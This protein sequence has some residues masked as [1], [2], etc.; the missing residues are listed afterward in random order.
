M[1]AQDSQLVIENFRSEML[2]L[3]LSH[4]NEVSLLNFQHES[5]QSQSQTS[6]EEWQQKQKKYINDLQE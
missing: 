2:N 6:L 4:E 3:R 5:G 1:Q